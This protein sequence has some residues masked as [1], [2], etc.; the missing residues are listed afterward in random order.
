MTSE[1][2]ETSMTH[3]RQ[4]SAAMREKNSCRSRDSGVVLSVCRLL[5]PTTAPFVPMR[6]TL[7]PVQYS[8]MFFMSMET[9]VL[10]LVPV[11]PTIFSPSAGLP[12]K[13]AAASARAALVSSTMTNG[14]SQAGFSMHSTA[15]AP[16]FTAAGI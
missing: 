11:T 4:P 13:L 2:E 16:A 7:S 6:P 5:S 9:V 1:W 14:T 12:K 15:A 10:P 8:I 3:Q